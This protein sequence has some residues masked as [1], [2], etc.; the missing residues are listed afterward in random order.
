MTVA[1]G[2]SQFACKS[3]AVPAAEQTMSASFT[4]RGKSVWRWQ[5]LTVAFLHVNKC[6]NGRPTVEER[7]IFLP[8]FA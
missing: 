3:P 1:P 8:G 4:A 6:A 2:F 7:P 5:I